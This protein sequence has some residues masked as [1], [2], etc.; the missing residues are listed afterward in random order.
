MR[1]FML[2][3]CWM[4]YV[5]ILGCS[6]HVHGSD[7]SCVYVLCSIQLYTCAHSTHYSRA[8]TDS[9]TFCIGYM[10]YMHVHILDSLAS[11][12]LVTCM[13]MYMCISLG[14]IHFCVKYTK[15]LFIPK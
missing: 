1:L 14:T 12:K 9:T 6:Y 8:C 5:N 10:T 13:Y 15:D 7:R 2:R 4:L 11:T 3:V